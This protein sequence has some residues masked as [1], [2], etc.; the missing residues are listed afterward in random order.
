[1]ELARFERG[2]D[3]QLQA[4]R[5]ALADGMHRAGWKIGLNFPEAQ[6]AL[7]IAHAAVGWLDGRQLHETGARLPV[8]SGARFHVEAE[9]CLRM[10]GAAPTV[11]SIAPALEIVDYAQSWDGIDDILSHSMFHEATVV[12]S[13]FN[14]PCP[15]D[16]GS[17]WPRLVVNDQVVR[18]PRSDLVPADVL[19][20]VAFA[21]DFLSHFGETLLAGDLLL[22]GS[23][24][25]PVSVAA[26][27]VIVA[28][29]GA[30]GSA[31]VVLTC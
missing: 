12:G 9:I 7:G 4:V 17:R 31:T 23:F 15:R 30:C 11:A 13:P 25:D 24:T 2:I 18:Q 3:A 20:L 1:M 27:D 21:S 28:E 22:S 19:E 6:S 14:P 8:R 5:A 10:S 26:G 16:L 29:F